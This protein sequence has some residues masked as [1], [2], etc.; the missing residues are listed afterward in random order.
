MAAVTRTKGPLVDAEPVRR[1]VRELM[2]GGAGY[3]RIA[4]AAGVNVST[5]NHMLYDR[6]SQPRSQRLTC[7]N[8][9]R[10]LGVQSHQ[11]STGL[12]DNTGSRRRLQALMAVGWPPMHLGGRLELHQHYV[13]EIQ[14]T[15]KVFAKTAHALAVAYNELWN[16]Q[17]E[18]HGV[19]RQAANRFRN[20]A[21]AKGWPPP[22]AWDDDVIDDPQAQPEWTGYCGT[23]R[24]WWMHSTQK[25]PTCER[26]Q[27]AH[28]E[29]KAEHRVLPRDQYIA[30]VGTARAEA[31][32]RGA[33]IAHDGRELMRFGHTTEQAAARLGITRD[34][35]QQE[36]IRHPEK[37][38]EQ[39]AA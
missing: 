9:Q 29:W 7:V 5:I 4:K 2:A 34:Y 35:L 8:A 36:L 20:Y 10:I 26:C 16:Q 27:V 14:R 30:A 31:A 21:R 11:I 37:A 17:P 25:L 23:D 3:A 28:D 1:H 24:G 15:S 6:G 12:V 38:P 22:A 33:G 39:V 32:T 18:L 13:S 19:T